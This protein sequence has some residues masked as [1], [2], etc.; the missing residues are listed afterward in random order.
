[1]LYNIKRTIKKLICK[2]K[3]H[4]KVILRRGSNV[5]LDSFFEGMNKVADNATFRGYMGYG[6]Y[7]GG[8]SSIDGK[9]GRYSSVSYN[10]IT[11]SG[12][13][14]S[15]DFVSTHPA[16]FSAAKQAG[17][18]Y[19]DE[20]IFEETTYA[21]GKYKTVIGNDVWIGANV[22]IMSGVHIGDGAIIAAGA[23]VTRDVEPYEIVGGVP[24]KRIRMR[25]SEEQISYLQ[26]LRWW[27]KP[28]Q[29]LKENAEDMQNIEKMMERHPL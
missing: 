29:W 9:I 24:A 11:V 12:N 16:F 20:S 27:D 17:F 3:F 14:P 7:I 26:G 2:V 28:N 1:M 15:S 6:S 4:N 18:S 21:E 23:V 8:N 13:H 25:F 22:L 5:A 10:V 19:V